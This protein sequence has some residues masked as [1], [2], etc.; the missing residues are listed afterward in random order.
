M[1]GAPKSKITELALSGLLA[2]HSDFARKRVALV[3]RPHTPD[4]SARVAE[5]D[6]NTANFV[7]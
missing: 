6:A 5:R 3:Y 1:Y 7:A 4:E 2:P